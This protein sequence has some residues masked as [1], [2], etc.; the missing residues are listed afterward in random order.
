MVVLQEKGTQQSLRNVILRAAAYDAARKRTVIPIQDMNKECMAILNQKK[1]IFVNDETSMRK[2]DSSSGIYLTAAKVAQRRLVA[3]N[4]REK[5]EAKRKQQRRHS[6]ESC[7]FKRS[8]VKL[9]R[10]AKTP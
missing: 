8:D 1:V 10:N 2:P 5:E 4:R 9:F 6:P 7:I 3:D